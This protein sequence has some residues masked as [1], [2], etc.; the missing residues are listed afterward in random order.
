MVFWRWLVA[1]EARRCRSPIAADRPLLPIV[2]HWRCVRHSFVLYYRLLNHQTFHEHLSLLRSTLLWDRVFWLPFV[3]C[4]ATLAGWYDVDSVSAGSWECIYRLL[5]IWYRPWVQDHICRTTDIGLTQISY[6][7]FKIT[8]SATDHI[9]CC[10]GLGGR[11]NL[12]QCQICYR[13]RTFSVWHALISLHLIK[14]LLRSS[15][16]HY[17]GLARAMWERYLSLFYLIRFILNQTN[18]SFE[19]MESTI[20]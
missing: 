12:C 10:P 18:L 17:F 14:T 2:F 7:A 11:V 1:G 8:I 3:Y 4:L 19:L 6:R 13:C 16:S 20:G 5:T 9:C 15:T